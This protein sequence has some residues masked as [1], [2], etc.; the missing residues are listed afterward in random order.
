MT[1]QPTLPLL[2]ASNMHPLSDAAMTAMGAIAESPVPRQQINP[3]IAIRLER[4][5]LVETV[6]LPSP[7]KT[8]HGINIDHLKLTA[9][10]IAAL[11]GAGRI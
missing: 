5:R 11:V 9:A 1:S 4:D 3:G 8:H 10:G 2:R 7:Y 6:R